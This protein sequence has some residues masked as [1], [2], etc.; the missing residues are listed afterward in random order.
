MPPILLLSIFLFTLG[1]LFVLIRKT[2]ITALIGIEL[3]LVAANLNFVLGGRIHNDQVNAQIISLFVIVIA[4]AQAAVALAI[5]LNVYKKYRTIE[6]DEINKINTKDY[7][8]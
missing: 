5:T 4:A 2:I 8:G 6:L 7:S 1:T 3:I